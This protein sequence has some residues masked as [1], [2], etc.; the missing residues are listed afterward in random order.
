MTIQEAMEK[1]TEVA[2]VF[3]LGAIHIL[4]EGDYPVSFILSADV[5]IGELA[6]EAILEENPMFECDLLER[7]L[8][9]H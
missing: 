3:G 1:L 4:W 8:T 9:E 5:G 6:A 7:D 2:D